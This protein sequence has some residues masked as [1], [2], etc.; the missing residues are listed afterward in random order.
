MLHISF[1]RGSLRIDKV[2]DIYKINYMTPNPLK[3]RNASL[4][5]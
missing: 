1:M 2:D 4:Q 5:P 3:S